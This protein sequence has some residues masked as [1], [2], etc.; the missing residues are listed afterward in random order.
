M[1]DELGQRADGPGR[2]DVEPA[3][4]SVVGVV[5]GRTFGPAPAAVLAAADVVVGAPRHLDAVTC[6]PGAER[7]ALAGPLGEILDLVAA[8]A[9]AGQAVCVLASGDPGFFGIVRALGERLGPDRLRVH[10]APSS[11]SLA[12]AEIGLSWDD[13]TVITAH[14]RPLA[15]A[16]ARTLAPAAGA[17]VAVLTSPD[18]PPQALGRAL[19]AAGC[20]ERRVAVVSRLG[21]VGQ[22]VTRTDLTG[23]AC[24]DHD[25]L[26]VVILQTLD[27]GTGGAGLAWGLPEEA[28]AHRRRMITKAEVRAVILGKLA[29]PPS[30]VLWDVGAG[31]GS[32]GIEAARVQP[33]LQ[34][35]AVERCADDVSRI[36]ANAAAYRVSV[37]VV[38]G[39][40]PAALGALP[41]PDRVFVGGGGLRVLEAAQ[42]RLR[43]GGVIVASYALVDR[44]TAAWRQLGNLVQLAIARGA[45][46]GAGDEQ[47]VRLAA[48][49]PVFIC[50]TDE[51]A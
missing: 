32:V 25:P 23:L 11:V 9:D 1:A 43:P 28:F 10:P 33:G 20:A 6:A 2:L 45:G 39:T 21:D 38:H 41:D 46:V 24:G 7:V 48:E 49:N 35:V 34:V 19:V 13:A 29:L 51:S 12:F 8:R 3:R 50:W 37:D 42:A 14:G 4:V 16:V 5:G 15:E 18:V 36:H 17:K 30:G 31:S 40:A 27:G 47:G 26:S 44:A 22:A